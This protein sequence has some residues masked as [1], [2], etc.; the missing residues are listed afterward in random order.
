MKIALVCGHFLP[1]LGYIEVHLAKALMR[2]GHRVLVITSDAVPAYVGSLPRDGMEMEGVETVRLPKVFSLGQIVVS[3]GIRKELRGF[4]P[5]FV[6]TVGL[7]K[8]FVQ[9]VFDEKY[10]VLVLYGDNAY[11]H[12]QGGAFAKFKSR[13]LYDLFKRSVYR[14]AVGKAAIHVAYTPESFDVAGRALGGRAG[15]F[16]SRRDRFIHLGYW[17]DEFRYDENL[18]NQKREELGF[19]RDDVVVVTCG[20]IS[21]EKDLGSVVPV[22]GALPSNYKWLIVGGG[23]PAILADL[24]RALETELEPGRFRRVGHRARSELNAF[25]CAGDI[26]LFTV[27]AISNIEAAG[28]GLPLVLPPT[29]SLSALRELRFCRGDWAGTKEDKADAIRRAAVDGDE[30]RRLGEL[31]VEKLSWPVQANTLV[32]WMEQR[33]SQDKR[34]SE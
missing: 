29:G 28:T 20:R 3:R 18:R 26:G 33:L 1:R 32:G 12:A 21:R 9:P 19:D 14:Q 10:P 4:D 7:G 27:P 6:I 23:D 17:P 13:V 34:T 24:D 22:L 11:S 5:D 8:R 25:Y 15:E 30:R 31:A 16:L 2:E